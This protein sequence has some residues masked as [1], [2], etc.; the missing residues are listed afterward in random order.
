MTYE[1]ALAQAQANNE[2]VNNT[3]VID[4]HLRT[5]AV[6]ESFILGVYNDKNT[7]VVPFEMPRYY[8][9]IDLATYSIRVNFMNAH[10]DGDIYLVMS[11]QIGAD[12]ITFDWV[13]NRTAYTYAGDVYFVVCLIKTDGN[14][15]VTTE[16]NT[17]RTKVRVLE[18]LEVDNPIP[19]TVAISILAQIQNAAARAE[20][21]VVSPPEIRDGFWWV[22][23]AT[24]MAYFNTGV[25]ANGSDS[26]A[27][28]A[29]APTFSTSDA[30]VI[31]DC[32]WYG[33]T[34][35]RFIASHAAGD[36]NSS[37]AV[38][39]VMTEEFSAMKATLDGYS[40][41]TLSDLHGIG[42]D[43]QTLTS[44]QQAQARANI[45]AVKASIVGTTIVLE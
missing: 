16:F 38:E 5:I 12:S 3:F 29:M 20:A 34:L 40:A 43:S 10:G 4:K 13:V 18:G 7:Q 15:I 25:Q 1:E 22:W 42:Y 27:R 14:G 45:G 30:Y 11:R 24:E 28:S 6:P 35:Y 44:E 21:V 19:E 32:V 41:V 17:T 37:H 33:N 31:G 9:D 8:N 26:R 39:T 2:T 23:D 36:W